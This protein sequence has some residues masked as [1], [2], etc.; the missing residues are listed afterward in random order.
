M[1]IETIEVSKGRSYKEGF[2]NLKYA[3]KKGHASLAEENVEIIG[4]VVVG[5]KQQLQSLIDENYIKASNFGA[6][7]EPY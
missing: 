5:D 3:L 1:K 2:E 6:I 4:V 7:I